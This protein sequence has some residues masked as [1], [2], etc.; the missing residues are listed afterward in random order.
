MRHTK[1][2]LLC[3]V[4]TVSLSA[5][6][7]S[8]DAEVE[9]A[10]KSVNALDDSNLSDL[11]LTAPAN[12]AVNYFR[13]TLAENPDRID[14]QRGLASSLVRAKKPTEAVAVWSR[15]VEHPESVPED[16][17]GFADALIRANNWSR[18]KTVLDSVPPTY[19]SFQR[20]RLEAMVAD[21]NKDWDRADSFYET[22]IGL[23]TQPSSVLNNWG[24]SKLTRGDFREA[25]RLFNEALT[26]DRKNFTTKNNLALARGA[27]RNYQLPIVDMTQ[28]ER[29]QLLHTLALTAVRQ[30]DTKTGKQLLQEAIETH[31][32]H[33]EAAARALSALESNE[34]SA[35]TATSG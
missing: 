6:G 29:A 20:Y 15:V 33:F 34:P 1:L 8:N 7:Q 12:E 30:G 35:V 17:V 21:S 23:T 16:K 31:P 3:L 24:F 18:A 14:L 5:C 28:V 4:G 11:M 19:E 9:R 27:Q 13:R 2:V 32:Q 22:A 10:I 26:Y 25:E